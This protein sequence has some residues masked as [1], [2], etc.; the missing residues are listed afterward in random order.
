VLP[1]LWVLASS[2][3]SAENRLA[4]YTEWLTVFTAVLA[5]GTLGL[6]WIAIKQGKQ[7]EKEFLATHRPRL[8]LRRVT[9]DPSSDAHCPPNL[10]VEIANTGESEG[11]ISR[12]AVVVG[13]HERLYPWSILETLERTEIEAAR[14]HALRSGD[15]YV[16]VVYADEAL[17]R[18]YFDNRMDPGHFEVYCIGYVEYRD[19]VGGSVRRTGFIR[20]GPFDGQYFESVNLPDFEYAD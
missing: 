1:A 20:R 8:I 4:V 15:S 7:I 11:I 14:N 6:F 5:V 18:L 17:T 19:R 10:R 3:P 13:A 2:A 16:V 9:L 12:L